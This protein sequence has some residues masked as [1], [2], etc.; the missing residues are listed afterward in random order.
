MLFGEK[1]IEA[2]GFNKFYKSHCILSVWWWMCY[3]VT[4]VNYLVGVLSPVSH[5]GL[6]IY[7]RAENKL[8]SIS[9]LF[10]P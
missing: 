3:F 4:A 7:I 1:I 2:H 9:K 5:K 6:Q 8:H 10:I